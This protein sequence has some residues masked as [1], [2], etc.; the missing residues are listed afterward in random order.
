MGA[1]GQRC[2]FIVYR[3]LEHCMPFVNAPSETHAQSTCTQV[4]THANEIWDLATS[5]AF[6]DLLLS[7]WSQGEQRL[8]QHSQRQVQLLK[9]CRAVNT[10]VM[11]E[12][13]SQAHCIHA[14]GLRS[15]AAV[16]GRETE[17]ESTLM[18]QHLLL[19]TTSNSLPVLDLY[20]A[21]HLL[22]QSKSCMCRCHCRLCI[23]RQTGSF[24][25]L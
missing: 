11:T 23:S 16:Y 5:S 17:T 8:L 9:K 1:K 20:S 4:L 15:H 3:K 12:T 18:H 25:L 13:E 7:V 14:Q 24:V 2:P 6:P 19:A 22:C 10:S 21:P